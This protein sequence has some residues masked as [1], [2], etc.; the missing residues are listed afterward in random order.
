M[1]DTPHRYE[2]SKAD[3]ALARLLDLPPP[4]RGGLARSMVYFWVHT[5]YHGDDFLTLINR[6]YLDDVGNETYWWHVSV[7]EHRAAADEAYDYLKRCGQL[8]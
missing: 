2:R 8:D 7:D 1:S 6:D 5:G 3:Q 4:P